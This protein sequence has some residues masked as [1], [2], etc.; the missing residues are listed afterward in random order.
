MIKYEFD[1]VSVQR[2]EKKL[3]D[4]KAKAPQA[5][6]NAINM[7]AR[8]A[9]TDLKNA[10]KKQ[11]TAKSG[12][13]SRGM[14][15]ASASVGNLQATIY[16]KGSPLHITHFKATTPKRG[17]KAQIIKSGSLKT[18]EGSQKIKA[19]RGL[20]G[21][22]WQRE[23]EARLPIKALFSNSAPVMVGN[24]KVLKTVTP[25]IN[26]A[27]RENVNKQVKRILEA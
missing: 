2:V 5:L 10:A 16:V 23:S 14:R 8:K 26:K 20:N 6:K 27:L 7:T 4:M 18:I 11:Y 22:I 9:R 13:I 12:D 3:G 21:L 1:P 19:F 15:L 24:D 25:T 17:A